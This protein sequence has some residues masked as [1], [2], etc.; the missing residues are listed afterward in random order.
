MKNRK[1]LARLSASLFALLLAVC[2]A[3]GALAE[4]YAVVYGT[5]SLNLR[6]GASSSSTCLGA[7]TRGSWVTVTGSQ[8]NFYA[9]RTADNKTGYMSKNFL[10]TVDQVVYGD[11]AIVNNQKATAF[12]NLR[13]NP[14]YTASVITILY[15]GVPLNILS[16]SNGWYRVQ[17]GNT[18]GYVRSEFTVRQYQPVGSKVATIKTPNNTAVNMRTGPGTTAS[19]RRQFAGDR[20]VSVLFEG[21]GWWYVCIDGYTGFISSDFLVDGLHAAR[22]Q[23]GEN[24]N[25]DGYALVHNPV[26]TQKLNLRELPTTASTTVAQLRNGTRLSVIVQGTEWCEVFVDQIAATGY[27]MTKYLSLYNLPVTPTLTI[28]HPQGSYVNLRTDAD[29]TAPVITRIPDGAKATVI[30]PGPDWS[31]VKYKGKVGYVI[32]YFTSIESGH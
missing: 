12:L 11:V 9:V 28:S 23:A 2:I 7:Y 14:S 8:N 24:E 5:D 17:M 4:S 29:M 13:S 1:R 3:G 25:G 16:E 27:V 30:A 15:N 18:V 10:N 6:A 31:K 26:S 21:T 20:Y 32:N 22:D 19:V